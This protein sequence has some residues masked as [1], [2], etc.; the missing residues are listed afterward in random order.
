[1]FTYLI[2]YRDARNPVFKFVLILILCGHRF[3][4]IV[5]INHLYILSFASNLL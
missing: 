2:Q 1:M 4:E 3:N 5:E